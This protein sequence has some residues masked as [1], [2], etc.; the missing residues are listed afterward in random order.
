M[1]KLIAIIRFILIA[2]SIISMMI[3]FIYWTINPELTQMQVWLKYWWVFVIG[4]SCSIL[5]QIPIKII[6]K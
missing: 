1:K 3:P 2:I 4:I 5:V 6:K